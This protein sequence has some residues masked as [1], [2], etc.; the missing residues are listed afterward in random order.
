MF[1]FVADISG[2]I[3]LLH[4]RFG[5]SSVEVQGNVQKVDYSSIY[6]SNISSRFGG[7]LIK[8]V[9]SPKSLLFDVRGCILHTA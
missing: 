9:T 4:E 5:Y 7:D 3:N 6:L 8:W 1:T 2:V